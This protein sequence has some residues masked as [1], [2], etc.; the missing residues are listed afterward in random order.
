[1]VLVYKNSYLCKLFEGVYIGL[2]KGIYGDCKK[3]N[4]F[5]IIRFIGV[6]IL[7]IK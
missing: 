7:V 3:I 5:K 6:I 2:S 1:M 4:G